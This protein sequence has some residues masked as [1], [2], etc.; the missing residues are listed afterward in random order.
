MFIISI[1]VPYALGGAR[2]AARDQDTQIIFMPA[3]G[4]FRRIIL[5]ILTFILS[6]FHTLILYL[7]KYHIELK[8]RANPD[9]RLFLLEQEVMNHHLCQHIKLELGLE[10]LSQLTLQ[11][12]LLLYAITSTRT[13]EGLNQIFNEDTKLSG[14][15]KNDSK[16]IFLYASIFWS[17]MSNVSSHIKGLSAHREYFPG[18][19]KA[20]AIVYAFFGITTRVLALIAFFTPCLGLFSVQSHWKGEQIKWHPALIENFVMNKS[21]MFDGSLPVSVDSIFISPRENNSISLNASLMESDDAIS[22]YF[23]INGTIQFGNSSQ[24]P[25]N[26]L[27]R[28]KYNLNGLAIP[29]HYSLYTLVNLKY[30]FLIFLV[31]LFTQT[32]SIFFVKIKFAKAFGKFNILEKIIHCI[33]GTNLPY[34]TQEWDT[35]RNGNAQDHISRM[36]ANQLEGLVLIFVNLVFKMTMLVPLYVLGS[37]LSKTKI[38]TPFSIQLIKSSSFSAFKMKERHIFL[39]NSISI[40]KEEHDAMITITFLVVGF[41]S[42]VVIGTLFEA[43]FFN[44]YN[45]TYHP[46]AKILDLSDEVFMCK[47]RNFDQQIL[48]DL[49]RDMGEAIPMSEEISCN[50]STVNSQATLVNP[51]SGDGLCQKRTHENGLKGKH[52]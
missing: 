6:P 42:Y 30:Y 29:P 49:G 4:N 8:L 43:I 52:D 7:R 10:T 18:I 28:W 50:T 31:I 35:L 46:F 9:S 5:S 40:L 25:W 38:D 11:I 15:L 37:C 14:E 33:E 34:N 23:Q 16:V 26:H 2:L 39:Y 20:I 1:I 45:S 17:V 3:H 27:D 32:L 51:E 48:P 12:I 21:V 41:T 13:T 36:K 19:S 47:R 22:K 24:I 44:L